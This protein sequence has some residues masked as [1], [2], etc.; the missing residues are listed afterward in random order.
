MSIEP[1][2]APHEE[3]QKRGFKL[4]PIRMGPDKI[5]P[6]APLVRLSFLSRYDSRFKS[7]AL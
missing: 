4:S 7:L 2:V 3:K 5:E 1:W 6:E